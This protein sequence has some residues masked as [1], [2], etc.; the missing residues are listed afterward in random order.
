MRIIFVTLICKD[1]MYT[2]KLPENIE[3]KYSIKNKMGKNLLN[4]KGNLNNWEIVS[5]RNAKIINSQS[6]KLRND[7]LTYIESDDSVIKKIIL[8]ENSIFFVSLKSTDEIYILYCT[9]IYC[10]NKISFDI[11]DSTEISVGRSGSNDIIYDNPLIGQEHFKLFQEKG[12]WKIENFDNKIGVFVNR[13]QIYDKITEIKNGDIIY[14]LNIKIV[15]LGNS[16][17]IFGPIKDLMFKYSNLSRQ[18]IVNEDED[19]EEKDDNVDVEL[20]NDKDYFYRSPRIM[21]QLSDED[22]IID[23]PPKKHEDNNSF[24]LAMAS[25]LSMGV[26]AIASLANAINKINSGDLQGTQLFMTLCMPIGMLM[27]SLCIPIIRKI[28][29]RKKNKT[30]ESNRQIRYRKYINSKIIE[31]N[32]I[33]E[34]QMNILE[35]KNKN[36]LEC[37]RI[38]IEKD[39]ALWERKIQDEDFLSIRV[40]IGAVPLNIHISEP[41]D[42][43]KLEDDV[44]DDIYNDVT[45]KSRMLKDAPVAISLVEKYISAIICKDIEK[46]DRFFKNIIMQLIAL[47]NYGDLKIVMLTKKSESEKLNFI[48][49]LP[50]IW[51]DA[52]KNRFFADEYTD[53]QNISKYLENELQNRS[54]DEDVFVSRSSTKDYKSFPTYYLIIT[55]D[56]INVSN[57]GII[58]KLL[59]STEN[60]GFSLLCLTDNFSQ[61]PNECKAFIDINGDECEIIENENLHNV[62]SIA[63][64]EDE[65]DFDFNKVCN[66]ISNIP[67]KLNSAGEYSLPDK[68]NFLEMFDVGNI[69]QLNIYDRW[70][71]NDSTISIKAKIGID[72]AGSDIYLDAHEKFHG[73]HGLIAG[74]TGSG[75][76]EFIITYILS[77]AINYHPDDVT[78]VLVDYKGGGL[79][80]A[81]K[82]K[83]IQLPHL[84]GTIT[85]I[86]VVGLQRSLESIESELKRRQVMFNQAKEI[87]NESTI[88]IYK[89]QRYYHEGVLKEPISHLFI[90]CDEFAELK[91]QQPDFMAELMSV[92]RIGRSLGVHLILA[93]QKPAGV[94]NEQIRSNSKFGICLKVQSKSDSK[95]IIKKTD[96]AT[97]KKAGQFYINVGNDEYF[98]LGQSGYT[99][100]EYSPSEQIVKNVNNSVDFIS[101]TG[102]IIKSL[103]E[104]EKKKSTGGL[105]DQLTN[106]VKYM[107]DLA[108][109]KNIKENQLWLDPIPE[110]IY[111]DELREKYNIKYKK[112]EIN[113]I[114]GEYDDPTKQLQGVLTLNFTEEGNTVLYGSAESGKEMFINTILYD[115]MKNYSTQELQYYILDFGTEIF[116][117]YADSPHVG[118]VVCL[119]DNEKV[120]RLFKMINDE[121]KRRKEI[122]LKY[123]GDYRLY[124]K[125][126]GKTMPMIT[127]IINDF[128]TFIQE[129][130][131]YEGALQTITKDCT[132]YGL[133]FFVTVN[134]PTEVRARFFQNFRKKITL[135]LVKDDDYYFI[136]NGARKKR[137]SNL[138]GRGLLTI[139]D[140]NVYEFQ[141]ARVCELEENNEFIK[142]F[143]E[144]QKKKNKLLT[145]K[146]PTLPEKVKFK[147][148][149]SSFKGLESVPIGIYNKN[150]KACTHDFKNNL[151]NIFAS[152]DLDNCKN[153]V[154]YLIKEFELLDNVELQIIDLENLLESKRV[155]A[156]E[157]FDKFVY[158]M[159]KISKDKDVKIEESKSAPSSV[160]SVSLSDL[161]S[162][163]A[164]T[165]KVEKEEKTENEVKEFDIE[166]DLNKHILYI[167]IGIDKFISEID[168]EKFAK[169]LKI[170]ENTENCSFVII[171]NTTK[172]KSH[173]MDSWYKT[174]AN[175]GNGLWIG[176]GF[177]AQYSFTHDTERRNIISK[178]GNCMGYYVRKEKAELIK[179]LGIEK[180]EDE[181]E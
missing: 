73:P 71:N 98:A 86:D 101:N 173:Q 135:Q 87:A 140:E 27:T 123:N 115:S 37:E 11:I 29:E 119:G 35:Y 72:S 100:V 83:D 54:E 65:E 16:I 126:S 117:M 90:I 60:L 63:T 152:K 45:R 130:P 82:K 67:I 170:A 32:E 4:I 53:M 44:L 5:D 113:P 12:K 114:F 62:K 55:N 132:K 105:G 160:S 61:L 91:Q 149:K 127:I 118:D 121:L 51:D 154:K 171:D 28:A 146:I 147:D 102:N 58:S 23:P 107:C 148:V 145:P 52:R 96:G 120:T 139:D 142:K 162:L 151:I 109:E 172:I 8:K 158:I 31:L 108:D 128:G 168:K 124:N 49:M 3:G 9:P 21:S 95:D 177:D 131:N 81:F 85:N 25:S 164:G 74:T 43:F 153:F 7:K 112:N 161:K 50:H 94:V 76:S 157:E 69:E 2:I 110:K 176:N 163:L 19:V 179:I 88:D 13:N 46:R 68:Y 30:A 156:T 138:Y 144:E 97:L 34:E 59:K 103:D 17:H 64:L 84:V 41:K 159:D 106:I 42:R 1:N 66:V 40:G 125:T 20:Y 93:T 39:V 104:H 178:C 89:Y 14:I 57:L 155:K 137:P 175:P 75:K 80:G 6:I 77:L 141:T 181:D 180:E 99:G 18:D 169:Y 166:I 24:I 150:I 122:L 165:A 78:F 133:L 134:S 79:A 36:A 56:Y 26:M 70:T 10:K 15:V 22:F 167:I 129:F 47:H 92:S 174:C 116:R 143:I 111:V 136:Y 48:K 38:I 33:M